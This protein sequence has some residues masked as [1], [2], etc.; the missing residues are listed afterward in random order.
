MRT[1]LVVLGGIAL[2]VLLSSCI[3]GTSPSST[4]AS[5]QTLTDLVYVSASTDSLQKLDAYIP[6]GGGSGYG[7]VILVHGGSWVAG[8]KAD[9]STAASSIMSMGYVTLNMNYRLADS[10]KSLTPTENK[11]RIAEM[12][13]DIESAKSYVA[14]RASEWNCN[15]AKIVLVGASAGAHL[16]LLDT[17]TKNG[18]GSVKACV[19]LS[20]PTDFTDPDFQDNTVTSTDGTFTVLQG[21]ELAVGT[22]WD[23]TAG[24]TNQSFIDASPLKQTL[25]GSASVQFLIVHGKIDTLVPYAQAESMATALTAAGATAEFYLSENDDHYLTNCLMTVITTKVSPLLSATLR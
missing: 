16:S 3:T 21:L 8:D 15:P 10:T 23:T 20:G 19:S 7:V 1:N 11:V 14:T 6:A 25:S 12:L 9:L 18:S 5:A 17:L 4:T 24:A 2:V 13:A 22:K